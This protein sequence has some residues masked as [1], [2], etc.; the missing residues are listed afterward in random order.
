[1]SN[2]V[3][4]ASVK[5][6]VVRRIGDVISKNSPAILTGLAV[7]GVVTTAVLAVQATPKAMLLISDAERE[8]GLL[9]NKEIIKVAWKP[10]IPALVMGGATAACIIGANSINYK[11]NA[12]LAG[13]YSLAKTSLNEYQAKVIET[14]G[15]NKAQK[16]KDEII[17]E[18]INKDPVTSKEVIITGKGEMLCYDVLSGRYFKNDIEQL[19]RVQNDLNYT[20]RTDMWVSLN[21]LYYAMGLAAIDLG[22][23]VGW[24]VDD[25]IDMSFNS[26][27]TDNGEPCLVVDYSVA[28]Q[29]DYK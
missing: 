8:K 20:L 28:P 6:P 10:Y 1:M 12:A 7:A 22:E 9:S 21:E 5:Q 3:V 18:K 23:M 25:P 2:E 16:I 27:L 13:V 15:E 29:Y 24:T 11:R 26:M 19:R 14:I 4:R 17:Q